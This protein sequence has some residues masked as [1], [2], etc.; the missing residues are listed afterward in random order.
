VPGLSGCWLRARSRVFSSAVRGCQ[1]RVR[2]TRP[3]RPVPSEPFA[4]GNRSRQRPRPMDSCLMDASGTRRVACPAHYCGP[5]S[6][7]A[8]R[9]LMSSAG[10]DPLPVPL[11]LGIQRGCRARRPARMGTREVQ[12]S[13]L[14]VTGSIANGSW[15]LP[16]QR[17]SGILTS[18]VYGR[19]WPHGPV[20]TGSNTPP[21]TARCRRRWARHGGPMARAG[22]GLPGGWG[23]ATLNCLPRTQLR[24]VSIGVARRS[25]A[26]AK[27]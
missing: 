7:G 24:V 6:A 11:A 23:S 25:A 27:G 21:G 14:T 16:R 10:P 3:L 4:D 19:T 15:L 5:A 26:A 8:L 13:S 18:G 12:R 22:C 9:P 20:P 1:N 2:V 17:G